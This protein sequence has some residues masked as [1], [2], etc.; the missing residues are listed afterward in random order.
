MRRYITETSTIPYSQLALKEFKQI[1]IK[2]LKNIISFISKMICIREGYK[3][4]N[5]YF[6]KPCR[7]SIKHALKMQGVCDPRGIAIVYNDTYLLL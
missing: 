5:I 3:T 7:E 6:C 4:A 2:I 1:K